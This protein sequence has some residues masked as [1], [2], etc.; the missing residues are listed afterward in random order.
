MSRSRSKSVDASENRSERQSFGWPIPEPGVM[1]PA[2]GTSDA[3]T[4]RRVVEWFVQRWAPHATISSS[5]PLGE[6]LAEI[7][8]SERGEPGREFSSREEQLAWEHRLIALRRLDFA[9]RCLHRPEGRLDVHQS[10]VTK[11]LLGVDNRSSEWRMP[12]GIGTMC[13]AGHLMQAGGGEIVITGAGTTGHDI[14]WRPLTGGYALIERKDRAFTVGATES[15]HNRIRWV[16]ARVIDASRQFCDQPGAARILAVGFPG[17]VSDEQ[18]E[19]VGQELGAA[20]DEAM[21]RTKCPER[22][23][24]YLLVEFI[25][26]RWTDGE[27]FDITNQFN[28]FDLGFEREEWLAVRGAFNRAFTIQGRKNAE[29]WP[30]RCF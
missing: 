25:G 18:V 16:V 20:L 17:Y 15:F 19:D 27:H 23:P 5:C 11:E 8:K 28:P 9:I 6:M 12:Q 4:S 2:G 26:S 1:Q 22:P 30:I 29:P 7:A 14:R 3:F 10:F 13:L 21:G 24:D